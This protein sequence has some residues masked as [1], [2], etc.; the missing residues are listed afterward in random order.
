MITQY[1]CVLPHSPSCFIDSVV[2]LTV[3]EGHA[4]AVWGRS[5]VCR[6]LQFGR[7]PG[8]VDALLCLLQEDKQMKA[9][10]CLYFYIVHIHSYIHGMINTAS[11][12]VT[13]PLIT[14]Q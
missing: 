2:S 13:S 1:I 8:D 5:R 7:N 6:K 12:S 3:M 10:P 11:Q 14:Y 9:I 4:K